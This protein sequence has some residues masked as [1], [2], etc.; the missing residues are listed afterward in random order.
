MNVC[1]V[2]EDVIDLLAETTEDIDLTCVS[3][4]GRYVAHWNMCSGYPNTCN[5]N[6]AISGTVGQYLVHTQQNA[7]LRE[8]TEQLE[9][10]YRELG[11]EPKVSI[12]TIKEVDYLSGIYCCNQAGRYFWIPKVFRLALKQCYVADPKPGFTA[13][14]YQHAMIDSYQHFT[15]VPV[16]RALLKL[17]RRIAGPKRAGKV[18]AI[19]DND[20]NQWYAPQA[21]AVE[22]GDIDIDFCHHYRLAYVN[23]LEMENIIE[24]WDKD[25]W[26]TG[27]VPYFEECFLVDVPD[28]IA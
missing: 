1:G 10:V 28:Y 12:G 3:S 4:G 2:R 5:G 20:R 14:D 19:I 25:Y 13:S 11:F 9:R 23:L 21:S 7:F 26:F 22:S 24:N 17:F 6:S 15:W 16:L 8:D 27:N 18:R